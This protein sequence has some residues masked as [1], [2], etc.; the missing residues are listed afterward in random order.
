[1]SVLI[2]LVL[3]LSCVGKSHQPWLMTLQ[4]SPVGRDP[5]YQISPHWR[6]QR[7]CSYLSSVSCSSDNPVPTYCG[8]SVWKTPMTIKLYRGYFQS[9]QANLR[10]VVW[11]KRWPR[12]SSFYPVHTL[13]GLTIDAMHHGTLTVFKKQV[14]I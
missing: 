14:Y 5:K 11:I 12:L 3:V 10:T 7:R 8:C 1:M 6:R 9:N 13:T 2:P 4:R